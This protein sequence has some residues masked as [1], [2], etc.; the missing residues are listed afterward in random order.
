MQKFAILGFFAVLA[1]SGTAFAAN[2]DFASAAFAPGDGQSS[3]AY[4]ASDGVTLTLTAG[5]NW[6][7]ARLQ[8]D[9]TDG[10]G[11]STF[12]D[13][14]PDEIEGA[15]TLTL[16]FSQGVTVS[17]VFITDLFNEGYLEAG[18]YSINGGSAIS[19][20]AASTQTPGST[21]GALTLDLDTVVTSLTFSAPSG[22]LFRQN[23]FAVRGIN[24]TVASRQ[25]PELSGSAAPLALM[26]LLGCAL[27]VNDR[28]VRQS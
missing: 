19:F 16:S 6:Q 5:P 21:N 2:L 10:F 23:D 18:T 13:S 1:S 25:V 24:Y 22:G 11:V 26:L 7:S 20:A 27:V 17:D 9:S 15:E 14:D 8:Q 28:R 4:T 12:L 3:F